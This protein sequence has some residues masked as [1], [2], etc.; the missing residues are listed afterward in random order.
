MKLFPVYLFTGFLD[1]GKT[2]RICQMLRQGDIDGSGRPILLLQCESGLAGYPDVLQR[3]CRLQ[4]HRLRTPEECTRQALMTLVESQC[5]AVVVEWNGFWPCGL[6]EQSL[7]PEWF[8]AKKYFCA[9]AATIGVYAA[10]L[11]G[12]TGDKISYADAVFFRGASGSQAHLLHS[13]VRQYSRR[14]QV[15]LPGPDG[16]WTP[17]SCAEKELISRSDSVQDIPDALYGAWFFDLEQAPERYTGRKLRLRG[18]IICVGGQVYFGRHVTTGRR[19]DAEF[20]GLPLLGLTAWDEAEWYLLEAQISGEGQLISM[21]LR[22]T[23][24]PAQ[25]IAILR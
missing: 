18:R 11:P 9:D 3:S 7:P 1:G 21:G 10:N 13:L 6:L 15:L 14:A 5:G 8:L 22:T 4:I 16:E 17:A 25:E 23:Y 24:P 2:T 12:Q 20:W 19:E